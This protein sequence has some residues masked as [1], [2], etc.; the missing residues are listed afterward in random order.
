MF[1]TL[2]LILTFLSFI[3]I[4]IFPKNIFLI[5]FLFIVSL[6]F[7]GI[8]IFMINA[9]WTNLFL[10]KI[11]IGMTSGLSVSLFRDFSVGGIGKMTTIFYVISFICSFFL[12]LIG[13]ISQSQNT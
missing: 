9:Q 1:A 13:S 10:E 3:E 2:C 4:I 8:F 5:L 11:G 7:L 6:I 12:V